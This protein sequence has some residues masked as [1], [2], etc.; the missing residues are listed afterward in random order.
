MGKDDAKGGAVPAGDAAK[1]AKIFKAKCAQCHSGWAFTD[2]GFH[3]I[4]INDEDEGRFKHL[5]I[6]SMKHAFKTPTLR[7]VTRRGPYM[8]GGSLSSLEA[9]V[10]YY[11]K[12]GD[13]DRP[14]SKSE[15]LKPLKL[16][17]AEK[18][19]L[20]EFLETLTSADKPVTLP[21]LPM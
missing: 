21:D 7:N 5:Q 13:A 8:H 16:S 20:V 10:D 1:G 9:V 15:F 18:A 19:Q 4:G 3:D 11:N 2:F 12:G 14:A 6:D 17:V